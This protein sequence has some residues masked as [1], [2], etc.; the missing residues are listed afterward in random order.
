MSGPVFVLGTQRSGTTWIANILDS[1]PEVLHYYEPFAPAYG[2]FPYFPHEF[3]RDDTAVLQNAQRLEA[4]FNR[5]R[6]LRS[7]FFDPVTLG[8]RQ[9]RF[10]ARVTKLLEQVYAFRPT[11][12]LDFARR[13][14]LVYLNR[15][16]QDPPLFFPKSGSASHVVLK[17]VRLYFKVSALARVFPGARFVHVVRH[18]AAVVNSM[19]HYMQRGS[20][21]ELKANMERFDEFAREV[22][23]DE[24]LSSH[25]DGVAAAVGA[26]LEERLAWFW[27][28]SNDAIARQFDG[29]DNPHHTFAYESLA[30]DP[31]ACARELFD[32]C[33]I[34]MSDPTRDY[35]TRSSTARGVTQT[36]LD[37]NRDSTAYF[38]AWQNKAPAEL[39]DTVT[40]VCAGQPLFELCAGKY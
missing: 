11:R 38:R 7:R 27:R 31:Y 40:N 1:H 6:V 36:V 34:P 17:E 18:P 14:R 26:S 16:G 15:L 21:V 20:L 37:T 35:I 32:A 12:T 33:G 4:D 8:E 5:L 19:L 2:I 25:A 24:T 13:F 3:S 29:L 23:T 10:E 22:A 30:M 28:V 9:F 39:V